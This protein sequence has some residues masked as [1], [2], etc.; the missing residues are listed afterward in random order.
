VKPDAQAA[1]SDWSNGLDALG[2]RIVSDDFPGPP[3][4]L[5]EGFRHLGQQ[6]LCWLEWAVGHGDPTRP[7]FQRQND[8]VTMWGGPNAD[9]VYRH[10]RVDPGCTYRI[11]GKMRSCEEFALAI[12]AGFRHT[13]TPA[14]LTE[15][16]AS[17]IGITA[18]DDFTILLG[19]EGD[20][21]NRVP[22]P[23]GAIMCSIREYYFDW[24]PVE[25]ATFTIECLGG[26]PRRPPPT[27]SDAMVEA[28]DLTERSIVFWNQYMLDARA[29]QRD[30]TF[31]DKIDVPRG[32]QLSQFG[33]CFYD[34]APG[35]ALH[36]HADVPDA[37]Y[38]SLQLYGMTWFEPYDVGKVTSRNH[39]Q[40]DLG[41]DG[42]FHVVVAHDDP[43]VPNWLDT[44][45]RREGL[46]NFRYFWGTK[47]P[48]LAADVIPAD[49]ARRVLP[50]DTPA[51]DAA[52]RAEEVA[53]RRDHLAWRFRT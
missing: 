29:K 5:D 41:A 31:G 28:L 22:L 39:R 33:F 51:V 18:G 14:T 37:R 10:A 34:L 24:Q 50:D 49:D 46:V 11:C 13:D 1:W 53:A 7:I 35:E 36:V 2:A 6:A 42:R 27:F 47:L 26:R 43:G 19:G 44:E 15:L 45:G 21:P 48:T 32:L 17:D 40:M 16:T 23:D 38:W 8:L 9:N 20:E 52:E 4:D 3:I 25:P 12:R 30:N